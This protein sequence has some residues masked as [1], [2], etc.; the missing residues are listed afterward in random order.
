MFTAFDA[1]RRALDEATLLDYLERTFE[2]AQAGR[3]AE[4]TRASPRRLA[5]RAADLYLGRAAEGLPGR[6]PGEAWAAIQTDRVFA[7]PAQRFAA[8]RSGS[9]ASTRAY[10]FDWAPRLLRGRAGACHS[11]EL[12]FVFGTVRGRVLRPLIGLSPAALRLSNFMQDAWL[13]FARSGSP[14]CAG[15]GVWPDDPA[16]VQVLD[17]APRAEPAL[18]EALRAFWSE[19]DRVATG[20][21]PE[22]GGV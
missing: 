13:G 21:A 5:E 9:G 1:R 16:R 7:I 18:P 15:L 22:A 8:A 3:L 11:M 12:P 2:R 10:R 4:A 14:R 6:S 17:A 19:L 20:E